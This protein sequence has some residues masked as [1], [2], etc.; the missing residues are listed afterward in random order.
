[1]HCS[2]ASKIQIWILLHLCCTQTYTALR[3]LQGSHFLTA[4]SKIQRKER[5]RPAQKGTWIS[6]QVKKATYV[7]SCSQG[8][9]AISFLAEVVH[10]VHHF[11]DSLYVLTIEKFKLLTQQHECSL[12]MAPVLRE[13]T[14]YCT[15]LWKLSWWSDI[16]S[17][18][19]FRTGS[20]V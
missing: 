20:A 18:V 17:G 13:V 7:V 9:K 14:K 10:R 12:P 3:V 5:K 19:S 11:G 4:D 1:M 2:C 16:F 6:C 15:P 8:F